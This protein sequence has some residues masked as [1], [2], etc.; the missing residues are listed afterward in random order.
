MAGRGQGRRRVPPGLPEVGQ[1]GERELRVLPVERDVVGQR[2]RVQLGPPAGRPPRPPRNRSPSAPGGTARTAASSGFGPAYPLRSGSA[3]SYASAISGWSACP[4]D[5]WRKKTVAG[6]AASSLSFRN[7]RARWARRSRNRGP[8][9]GSLRH[10]A[11]SP[12]SFR[13]VI[14]CRAWS[15]SSTSSGFSPVRNRSAASSSVS[16]P[17]GRII[18]P[19]PGEGLRPVGFGPDGGVQVGQGGPAHAHL[20]QVLRGR[21]EQLAVHGQAQVEGEE[22]EPGFGVGPQV[23][24]GV[25][26]RR[27]LPPAPVEGREGVDQAGEGGPL[28]PVQV[29]VDGFKNLDLP[30]Q[31]APDLAD[32]FLPP[33]PAGTGAAR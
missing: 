7:S 1:V 2:G 8:F 24:E 3:S 9:S 19:Q 14:F 10:T 29:G 6:S 31:P 28:F 22:P 17:S 21:P 12:R 18:P 27:P 25:G 4:P 30:L 15:N 13:A 23:V 5:R 32:R 16:H 11:A 26:R 20:P 33:R